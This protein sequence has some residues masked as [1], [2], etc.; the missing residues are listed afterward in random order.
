MLNF[1]IW[2]IVLF[3]ACMGNVEGI[4]H[5]REKMSMISQLE[6]ECESDLDERLSNQRLSFSW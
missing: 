6:L 3:M 2:D 1:G 4:V 5:R